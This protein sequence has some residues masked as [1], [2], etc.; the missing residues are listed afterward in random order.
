MNGISFGTDGWRS[1]MTEDFTSENV[2]TVTQAVA[3]Y[4]KTGT[5][6]V[7]YDCRENSHTF[8][9]NCCGVLTE[10]GIN[11]LLCDRPTPTPVMTFAVAHYK[12][13][14]AI[15]ITASH[16]PPEY[17]GIKFIPSYAGPATD[18]ITRAIEEN[19]SHLTDSFRPTISHKQYDTID[20][21]PVYETHVQNHIDTEMIADITPKILFNPMHG[22]AYGYSRLFESLGCRVQSINDTCTPHFGGKNPDPT[23]ENLQDQIPQVSSSLVGIALDG[24]ADRIGVLDPSGTFISPNALFALLLYYLR[25]REG[26]VCRTVSTTHWV[27]SIALEQGKKVYEVPVGFK[28]VGEIMRTHSI[29]IGGEE[30]GGFSFKGHIPEKD[31]LLTALYVIEACCSGRTSPLHLL[32]EVREKFGSRWNAKISVPVDSQRMKLMRIPDFLGNEIIKTDS[33]DGL[34][35]Y[36]DKGWILFRPSGTEP[37]FRVYVESDSPENAQ[38]L[39]SLGKDLLY[40]SMYEKS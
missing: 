34:K 17:N 37:V 31:G 15:M 9:R 38:S 29:L 10:N 30:S 40:R 6:I 16:N 12:L 13:Q 26:D 5:I 28:Y 39:L 7:G 25:G 24:D 27:D 32:D 20:P 35:I 1:R 19:L 3:D 2:C 33:K 11:A 14:G 23:E 22:A 36:L 18:D 21:Y 8:A 4:V